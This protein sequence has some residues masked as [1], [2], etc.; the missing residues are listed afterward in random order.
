MMS[1]VFCYLKVED[2]YLE[3]NQSSDMIGL[4]N[5]YDERD[6]ALSNPQSASIPDDKL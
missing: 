6:L 2:I 4:V 1:R 5:L 3:L